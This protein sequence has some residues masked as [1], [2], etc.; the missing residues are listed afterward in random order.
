MPP[1]QYSKTE[2]HPNPELDFKIK[3]RIRQPTEPI[4]ANGLQV[5]VWHSS[6]PTAVPLCGE[7]GTG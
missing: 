7:D 6:L 5:E 1:E 3:N 4:T 2:A